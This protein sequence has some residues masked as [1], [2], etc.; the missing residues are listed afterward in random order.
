[1]RRD[2]WRELTNLFRL[3]AGLTAA[4]LAILTGTTGAT[5]QTDTQ[6]PSVVSRSPTP[7]ATGVSTQIVVRAIFNEPVQA[8]SVS[9]VLR[10]AGGTQ[11]PAVVN[12]DNESRM[13]SLDPSD[14][15]APST[16]YTATL[17]GVKDVAGNTMTA[18][19]VW[20]FTTGVPS[21]QQSVVFSGLTQPTAVEF[22]S[23]GRVFVAEKKRA[24][25]SIQQPDGDHADGLCRP[26]HEGLQLLG[27]RPARHGPPSG[28]SDQT[29]RYPPVLA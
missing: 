23:D 8:G 9:F 13:A 26:A 5:A 21:F 11:L 15:L 20:S 22:A 10:N 24:D 4:T 6:P 19:V 28:F 12:Y 25:Q 7:S 17:S 2:D 18:P 14:D 16:S 3:T 1:M 29:L 27:P